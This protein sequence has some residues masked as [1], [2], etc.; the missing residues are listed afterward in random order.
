MRASAKEPKEVRILFIYMV[1]TKSH[2]SVI[3]RNVHLPA[4]MGAP[5]FFLQA[6]M[7]VLKDSSV[8]P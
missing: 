2:N 1:A 3:D 6:L 5:S 7:W 8:R 4:Q